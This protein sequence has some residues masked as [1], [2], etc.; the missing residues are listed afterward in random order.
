MQDDHSGVADAF[1][2]QSQGI[3]FV[4]NLGVDSRRFIEEWDSSNHTFACDVECSLVCAD[5][6]CS[7][8]LFCFIRTYLSVCSFCGALATTFFC[9]KLGHIESLSLY[10]SRRPATKDDDIGHDNG[11]G[12][13]DVEVSF[14]FGYD[15]GVFFR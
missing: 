11:T 9:C 10:F 7:M 1:G 3:A 4:H 6:V 15:L 8:T 13:G 2:C 5:V 12:I 14:G